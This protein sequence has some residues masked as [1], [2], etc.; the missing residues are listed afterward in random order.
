M[1]ESFKPALPKAPFII[2]DVI[3][4]LTA[5]LI[6]NSGD[7]PL[8]P[9]SF[10]WVIICVGMGAVLAC[11]PYIVEYRTMMAA[12]SV[13][14]DDL[15]MQSGVME[16]SIA[17]LTEQRKVLKEQID[18][19]E[20]IM[21]MVESLVKRLESRLQVLEEEGQEQEKVL[22]EW[23]ETLGEKLTED[24]EEL[25]ST[26]KKWSEEWTL[27]QKERSEAAEKF[28][29]RL[30]AAIQSLGSLPSEMGKGVDREDS[31]A[32]PEA[33]EGLEE[34]SEEETVETVE[35]VS[36]EEEL[37]EESLAEE[38]GLGDESL[39]A[40]E[41][42][43]LE[44]T[45]DRLGEDV[46]A[47]GG[48]SEEEEDVEW[49]SELGAEDPFETEASKEQEEMLPPEPENEVKPQQPELLDDLPASRPKPK[50]PGKETTTLVAQLLI[51]I[52]NKPYVRG[53]GPGLS[54]DVGVPMEFLE[55]GKWQWVAPDS[56]EPVVC[57]IYKNDEIPA[58]GDPIVIEPGQRKVVA[59]K[60][61]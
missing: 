55:I 11:L 35:V 50:K 41:A 34:W 42:E 53:K 6:A 22:Q 1:N 26:I 27:S 21:G 59:P 29:D 16:E 4:V 61:L 48:E 57:R 45:L 23:Q 19:N 24:R 40:E 32:E 52:G 3:L 54:E 56:S 10:F 36:T 8:E 2:G 39:D 43:A 33:E 37:E 7:G 38:P 44:D 28:L 46:D 5:I 14:Q 20:R 17:K 58:E 47:A 18:R 12:A 30:E 9:L 49:G 25:L 60:F 15:G 51:G 31:L 13:L